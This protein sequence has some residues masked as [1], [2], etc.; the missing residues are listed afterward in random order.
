MT[1][2]KNQSTVALAG[3]VVLGAAC[4]G[5]GLWG[6]HLP[7]PLTVS[8]EWRGNVG[9]VG[10]AILTAACLGIVERLDWRAY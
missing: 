10:M 1:D 3:A 6:M 4:V 8:N 5:A 9:Y 7:A 2:R